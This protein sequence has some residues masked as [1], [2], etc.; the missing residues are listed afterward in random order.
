MTGWR[1]ITQVAL[2]ALLTAVCLLAPA[3]AHAQYDPNDPR[4]GVVDNYYGQIQFL[5]QNA[6]LDEGSFADS[7][8]YVGSVP[9]TSLDGTVWGGFVGA[10]APVSDQKGR[11]WLAARTD[12][13][14]LDYNVYSVGGDSWRGW[15][16]VPGTAAGGVCISGRS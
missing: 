16:R 13:G 14:Y 4:F 8:E 12:A 9:S 11:I 2:S 1:S 7:W 10:A 6:F 15:A 3:T 5:Y